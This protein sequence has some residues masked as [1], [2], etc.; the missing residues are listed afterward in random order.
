MAAPA[1]NL[2][3]AFFVT[4]KGDEIRCMFNPEKFS[5][6][7]SNNWEGPPVPGLGAPPKRFGGTN[8]GTFSVNLVFDTT[9]TGQPVTSHTNKMLALL[10]TEPSL[11]DHDPGRNVARPQWV[12]FHWGT[13]IRT[14]KAI[15]KSMTISYTYFASDGTPLRATVD[16]S[17]EQFEADAQW[18]RQNPTSGTPR[19]HRTHQVQPGE[20][21][22][23]IA[24]RYYADAGRWRQLAAANGITDPLSLRPGTILMIPERSAT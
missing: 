5:F 22:D 4:E 1:T 19:P 11:P 7:A 14:F 18:A 9:D 17:F 13:A 24:A 12:R 6:T 8:S 15:A 16:A 20:T 21:L 2:Q 3:K 23:R 10:D